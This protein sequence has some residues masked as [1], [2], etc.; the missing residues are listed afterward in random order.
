[1]SSKQVC[2][3]IVA[4]IIAFGMAV[5]IH[6][7][8]V[9]GEV[10]EQRFQEPIETGHPVEVVEFSKEHPLP[11]ADNVGLWFSRIGHKTGLG[12]GCELYNMVD[13]H[14]AIR[15]KLCEGKRSKMTMIDA[16]NYEKS[17]RI[18]LTKVGD[19]LII[20]PQKETEND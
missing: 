19:R 20:E 11:Y 10:E 7:S 5:G 1:M 4:I 16:L 2:N 12:K 17:K 15:I 3:L 14:K 8:V 6:F 18:W 13:Q 9:V